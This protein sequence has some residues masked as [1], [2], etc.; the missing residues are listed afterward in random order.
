MNSADRMAARDMLDVAAVADSQ[1]VERRLP[2]P[3]GVILCAAAKLDP[4]DVERIVA[5]QR[6]KGVRFGEAA[7][8]LGLVTRTDV[9]RAL[10]RQFD[11]SY[12]QRGESAV[13]RAVVAAY[14][15]SSPQIEALR[16]ARDQLVLRWLDQ[17]T[18]SRTLAI[19]SAARREGRSFIA[20]NLAVVFAQLG[21]S[22]ILVDADL[23]SPSQHRFFGLDNRIGLSAVLAGRADAR[24]AVQHV[25]SLPGLSVLPAGA[26]PPN[27][28]D[29]LLRPAFTELLRQ[30][31]G[32]ASLVLID[33]PPA[34]T[35]DAQTI[36][37]RAGAALIVVRR[38]ASHLWRVQGVS[39]SVGEARSRVI[40]AV[41]NDF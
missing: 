12:I 3:I 23:R 21:H 37:V 18:E 25:P 11:L 20:A 10:A 33:C 13:S 28:Q 29:L 6:R 22:T 38:H 41:L 1:P 39:T 19:L 24:K 15:P 32:H 14:E 9:E 2:Q 16:A 26:I 5:L 35:S 30:L 4:K 17:E 34:S 27:P 31:G 7:R 8:A 36:A 40:G